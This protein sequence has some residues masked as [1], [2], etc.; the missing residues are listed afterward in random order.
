MEKKK[1]PTPSS[2]QFEKILTTATSATVV[3]IAFAVMIRIGK[4]MI[5]DLKDMGIYLYYSLFKKDL[6]NQVFFLNSCVI[7]RFVIFHAEP[8]LTIKYAVNRCKTMRNNVKRRFT[9]FLPT[10]QSVFYC[11]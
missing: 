6:N 7:K 2:D 5:R 11:E 8:R 9:C 10:I 1:R 3:L 4:V